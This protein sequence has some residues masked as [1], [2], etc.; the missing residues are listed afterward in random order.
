M[1]RLPA[2]ALLLAAVPIVVGPPAAA[3]DE[4]PEFIPTLAK[5]FAISKDRGNPILVWAVIDD[6]PD[7]RSDQETLKNKD[8]QKA[9]KGFLVVIGNHEDTHGTKDGTIDGKPAKV[10]ALAPT[11]TCADHRRAIDEI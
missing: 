4:G 3:A 7:N 8:V 1:I 9:M 5:A 10:C 6:D 2:A 11:I